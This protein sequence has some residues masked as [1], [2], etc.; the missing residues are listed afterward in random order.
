MV[1]RFPEVMGSRYNR[2]GY[3]GTLAPVHVPRLASGDKDLQMHKL[4]QMSKR[5]RQL[6]D[7][8]QIAHSSVPGGTTHPLLSD[9]L[10]KVK[11]ITNILPPVPVQN[12]SDASDEDTIDTVGTLINLGRGTESYFGA[13]VSI[14]LLFFTISSLMH[15]Q[16]EFALVCFRT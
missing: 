6:E 4:T 1:R 9:E 14:F 7:A 3:P 12:E 15:P 16:Q 5:V 13:T 10:L 11:N 8:L 2:E